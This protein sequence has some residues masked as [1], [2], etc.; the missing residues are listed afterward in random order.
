M[1]NN[2]THTTR[3]LEEGGIYDYFP[4]FLSREKADDLFNTILIS[5]QW[6]QEKYGKY[7]QPRLTA[8]YAVDNLS[9]SYSGVSHTAVN[10]TPTLLAI[11]KKIEVAT[12][13]F[14][15]LFNSF[16]SVLLN[17][18]RDGKDSVGY[19][20]DDERELGIRPIIASLSLGAPRTFYMQQYKT[21]DGSIPTGKPESIILEPGSLLLMHGTMQHFWKHSIPKSTKEIGPRINLTFR[22][23]K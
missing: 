6:G 9:Y 2:N 8:W 20:A 23:I 14:V 19:H 4:D 7:P 3:Y 17:Y 5:T 10:F 13:E 16:N 15:P 1:S 11:K 21:L 22:T 12:K 18:Y